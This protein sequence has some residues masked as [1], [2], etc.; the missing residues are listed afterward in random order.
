LIHLGFNALALI[1]VGP[2]LESEL[3]SRR[4]LV[5]ITVAQL[6][7]AL[8]VQ[9][10]GPG[11]AGAS[12]WLFGLLGFGLVY[13]HRH[14]RRDIRDFFIQWAVYGFIFSF[15]FRFNNTA[16]MGGFVGGMIMGFIADLTAARR[17]T[18]TWVWEKLFWPSLVV[19]AVTLGFMA[20]SILGPG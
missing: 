4:M 20:R 3:G 17:S 9:A 11:G 15:F 5:L 2:W 18:F 1:Q 12:G 16:H 10:L 7:T 14:G 6:T 8:A 13:F 19:W